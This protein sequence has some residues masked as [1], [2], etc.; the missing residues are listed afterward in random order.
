[1]LNSSSCRYS[2]K[3]VL[4][5]RKNILFASYED[6][7]GL[8]LRSEIKTSLEI[9]RR[10]KEQESHNQQMS[11]RNLQMDLG[12]REVPTSRVTEMALAQA[13][14]SSVASQGDFPVH[15]INDNDAHYQL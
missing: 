6:R 5:K 2:N 7:H 12:P 9:L 14:S 1:L 4:E 8:G 15:I 3:T 11:A 13:I 10:V